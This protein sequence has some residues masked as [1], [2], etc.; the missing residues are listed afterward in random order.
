[1]TVRPEW[2]HYD[3]YVKTP[4]MDWRY[5]EDGPALHGRAGRTPGRLPPQ[6]FGRP[7]ASPGLGHHR[8]PLASALRETGASLSLT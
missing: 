4:E 5:T 7:E 3:Y 1:M 2:S 6:A 8:Q